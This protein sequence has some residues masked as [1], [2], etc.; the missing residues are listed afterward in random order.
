LSHNIV[1]GFFRDVMTPDRRRAVSAFRKFVRTPLTTTDIMP[2]GAKKPSVSRPAMRH[3]FP[4]EFFKRSEPPEPVHHHRDRISPDGRA[5]GGG[6]L[7]ATT[8]A[9]AM[10]G[11]RRTLA[12]LQRF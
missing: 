11:R 7:T 2:R 12:A 3:F 4:I 10:P 6:G 9:P 1:V 5:T 8:A